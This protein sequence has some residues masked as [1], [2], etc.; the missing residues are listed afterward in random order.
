L[1]AAVKTGT[2]H[3]E[4]AMQVLQD[5]AILNPAYL[6]EAMGANLSNL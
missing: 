2:F 6:K 5:A 4:A 1:Y 3:P